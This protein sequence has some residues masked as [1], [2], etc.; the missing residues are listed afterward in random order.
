[1]TSKRNLSRMLL[2]VFCL[3]LLFAFSFIVVESHHDCTGEHCKI[4]EE[5]NICAGLLNSLFSVSGLLRLILVALIVAGCI[6]FIPFILCFC[7]LVSYKVKLT[8]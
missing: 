6:I 4:C 5:I 2:A 8:N 3:S 1:M 7:T